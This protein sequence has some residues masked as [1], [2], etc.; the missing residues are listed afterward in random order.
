MKRTE[1]DGRL[2]GAYWEGAGWCISA[3]ADK[4]GYDCLP[5][6][7][8]D[9]LHD[10]NSVEVAIRSPWDGA[11]DIPEGPFKDILRQFGFE[12]LE[13][14]STIMAGRV[15]VSSLDTIR[16]TLIPEL[17]RNPNFGFP[18][19]A[20]VW[21]EKTLH[22]GTDAESANDIARNGVSLD[23]STAGYFGKGFYAAEDESLARSNYAEFSDGDEQGLVVSFEIAE[24]AR[25]LDMRNHQDW[26]IW[27]DGEYE[28]VVGSDAF[29]SIMRRAGIDGLYDASFG[30]LVVYN[31]NIVE[32]VAI[33]EI[34]ESAPS[35]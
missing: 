12:T 25:I 31:T 18:R 26:Q 3:Q 20:D 7:R 22:H 2:F 21:P 14:T 11:P 23:M 19:G 13:G 1:E 24:G 35:P 34:E 16:D 29:P 9:D 15:P 17:M 27:Q 32:N 8:L 4:N 5:R 10:Y 28:D 30:G 6:A 33:L